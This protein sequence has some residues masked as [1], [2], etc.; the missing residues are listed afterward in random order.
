MRALHLGWL[1]LFAWTTPGCLPAACIQHGA[2]EEEDRCITE[3][4]S[5][6]C[7]DEPCTEG[8]DLPITCDDY[9]LATTC[10]GEGFDHECG[11]IW[12]RV[13]CD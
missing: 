2:V 10:E 11:G 13:P 3:L 4:D 8:D 6:F 7:G 5:I 12:Y 1:L 9:V